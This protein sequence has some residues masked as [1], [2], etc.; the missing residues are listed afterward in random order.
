MKQCPV[1]FA[2][3]SDFVIHFMSL[4]FS[5]NSQILTLLALKKTNILS[6]FLFLSTQTP[7]FCVARTTILDNTNCELHL[8]TV[9]TC[10]SGGVSSPNKHIVDS[11]HQLLLKVLNSQPHYSHKRGESFCRIESKKFIPFPS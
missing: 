4:P 6:F 11:H 5:L 1:F 8:T 10:R 3:Q 7:L 2:V 9:N